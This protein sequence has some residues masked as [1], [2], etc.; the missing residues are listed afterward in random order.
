MNLFACCCCDCRY[1]TKDLEMET[2]SFFCVGKIFETEISV[3]VD[4]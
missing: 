2:E 1:I 3:F 4:S